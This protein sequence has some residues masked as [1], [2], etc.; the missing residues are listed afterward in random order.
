M[1]L[2]LCSE[3]ITRPDVLKNL[4]ENDSKKFTVALICNAGDV[5]PSIFRNA[6]N[7]ALFLQFMLLG[8]RVTIID[9]KAFSSTDDTLY[10]NLKNYG[11]IWCSGGNSFWLRYV[12]KTSGFDTCIRNLLSGGVVYGGSSAGAVVAGVSLHPIELMDDPRKSPEVLYEGLGLVEH[13]IWPHWN[14]RKYRHL[15][16][17]VEK[18][19]GALAQ[20]VLTLKD[21]D[22]LVVDGSVS[23]VVETLH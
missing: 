6:V 4:L 8:F 12:M 15:Q 5:Y 10:Q 21:G 13:G 3:G 14:T 18:R 7:A 19:F 11:L 9:L 16:E 23:E 20:R 2:F 22:V 1:K 17:K